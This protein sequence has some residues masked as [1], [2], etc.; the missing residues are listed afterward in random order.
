MLRT[1]LDNI[2]DSSYANIVLTSESKNSKDL[3]KSSEV[4]KCSVELR[5]SS[6]NL[7]YINDKIIRIKT[8]IILTNQ[9]TITCR[10]ITNFFV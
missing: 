10:V 7:C 3:H 8:V 9:N 1:Q 2:F 5:I 4:V 6:A